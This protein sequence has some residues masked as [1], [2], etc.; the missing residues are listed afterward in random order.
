MRKS[1]LHIFSSK[2]QFSMLK[3]FYIGENVRPIF[4]FKIL[5][6]VSLKKAKASPLVYP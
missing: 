4:C 1:Y 6:L 5:G 3:I 2:S